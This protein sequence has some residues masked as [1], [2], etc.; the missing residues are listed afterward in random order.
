MKKTA[1]SEIGTA[2]VVFTSLVVAGFLS[3]M[4]TARAQTGLAKEPYPSAPSLASG[5][6]VKS[7]PTTIAAQKGK[8]TL[9]AFWTHQCINC[10]RTIPYWNDWAKKYGGTDVSV[11]SVHTPEIPEER[12]IEN[13]RRFVQTKGIVFPVLTDNDYASWNAYKVDAWPTTILIDKQGRIRGRW[14]GEL[15]YDNSGQYRQVVAAIEALR[16]E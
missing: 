14:V 4:T 3:P 16:K 11:L 10:K 1:K 15:N 2:F 7:Q 6:W 8:V 9:L 13:V 5:T 12:K